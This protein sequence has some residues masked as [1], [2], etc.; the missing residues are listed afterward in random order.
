MGLRP[1]ALVRG[2]LVGVHFLGGAG[3]GLGENF[4]AEFE[5]AS[6]VGAAENEPTTEAREPIRG[7]DAECDGD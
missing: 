7:A 5:A 2:A 6:L 3:L 1:C 4:G